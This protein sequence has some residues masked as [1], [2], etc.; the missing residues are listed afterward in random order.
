[1]PGTSKDHVA[2]YTI[3]LDGGDIP[4]E[5]RDRIKEIRVVDHLRLPD[6]CTIVITYPKAEGIDTHP[7]TIG[8]KLEVRLGAID[9][10]A[11]KT[12]FEGD[13]L[14]LL[15]TFGKGGAG[16]TVRAYDRAH[17]MHRSRKVRTFQNQTST[18][19]VKK[20][21]GDYGLSFEGESSG[22]P[23]DFMQQDNE[24]DWDFVLRLA[25]RCGFMF[26]VRQS[27][28]YFG[29]KGLD[30]TVELKWP[31]TLSSFEP[32]VTAVQQVSSVSV[33]AHDP[34]T[35]QAI[36][37]EASRPE[38]IAQI[39]VVRD[40]VKNAF[41]EATVHVATEPVKSMGEANGLAQALLDKLANGYIAAEGEG[42]G[43]PGV[44]A[45]AT[46]KVSGVG[47]SFSGTYRVAMSK[48]VLRSGG[49]TTQFA[50]SPSHTILGALG[51]DGQAA[52]A[53]F[54][55]NLVLGVVTNVNDPDDMGRVRVQYPAL[56]DEAESAWARIAAVSAG[57]ARGLL[58][59]PV[60]GEEVLVGFEHGDT[61]RPYVLGSLFNG[62]DKP[63]DKLLQEKDGS[64]ALQS[65]QKIYTESKK[66][67]TIKSNDKLVVEIS[68]AVEESYGGDWKNETKGKASVKATQPLELEGQSVSIKG[69][70][71]VTIESSATV[72][73]KVGG[74]SVEVSPA[75]VKISGPMI[76]IG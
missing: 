38:Q 63:G 6:V 47:S 2:L 58:M 48:H 3:L 27:K 31:D 66:L 7:F 67:Y 37:A 65:D 68:G 71:G 42:P 49:Y 54:S 73:L 22:E 70:T 23:H 40:D 34:K 13:I 15:P 32:R 5:Q 28:A 64:F 11:T 51:G 57:N 60:V 12:L 74:S 53:R 30:E 18:D 21:A 39:G 17:L 29:K 55:A 62:K 33:Y 61:T 1:M 4:A 50:N 45:G 69:Q 19:I 75:G 72:T 56:G 35:K 59:L 9:E 44:R 36:E 41:A 25:E 10:Q 76:N 16:L 14:T 52:A 8:K 24:T 43:N 26:R 20:V 46:V